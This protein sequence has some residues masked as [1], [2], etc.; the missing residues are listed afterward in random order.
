MDRYF[1]PLDART[2]QVLWQLRLA[3]YVHNGPMS[4]AVRDKQYIAVAAGNTLYALAL[5]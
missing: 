2:S 1:Y 5:P 3:G 4:Y